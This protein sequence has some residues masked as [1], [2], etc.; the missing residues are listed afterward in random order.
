MTDNVARSSAGSV[1]DGTGEPRSWAYRRRCRL[2][3][4]FGCRLGIKT[5]S[6]DAGWA[7]CCLTG[8]VS[9]CTL[10]GKKPN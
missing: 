9:T 7:D 2:A 1:G 6:S 8:F 4:P 10:L 3:G 5:V